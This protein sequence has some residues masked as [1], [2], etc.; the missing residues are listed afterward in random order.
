MLESHLL[1]GKQAITDKPADLRYGQSITDACIDW[2]QTVE[3]LDRLAAA[4][5]QRRSR[6]GQ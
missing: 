4:V 2:E 6:L 3:V 1:E 5:R